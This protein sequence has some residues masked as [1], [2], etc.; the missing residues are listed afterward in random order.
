GSSGSSGMASDTPGFY[1]DKLNKYRQMHGVAITYKE[2]ST[3]G[4][5]HDRRFTFQVLI[6]EKEFPEAKGRSKQEARNAAAKLA[7]DILDNENKVDCH[8]SGPSSG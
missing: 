2:L 1:M 7:V 6:D 3:S 8:T 4:P 5:P